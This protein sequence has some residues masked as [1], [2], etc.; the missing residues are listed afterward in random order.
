MNVFLDSSALSKRYV[1][2]QGTEIVDGILHAAS[3]LGVCI[4]CIPEV[5]SALCRRRRET[6]LSS[7][8]YSLARRA[9]FADLTDAAVIQITDSVMSRAVDIVE[10]FPLRSSDALHVASAAEWSADLFVTADHRQ[11]AAA[12]EY[13][14][15]V[16][17]LSET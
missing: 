11:S 6:L 13:G 12:R 17:E 4:I 2:E 14:L 15:Q 9:L 5:I 16:K 1:L 10:R 3:D 8:E 7:E